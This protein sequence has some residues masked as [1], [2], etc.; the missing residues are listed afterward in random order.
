MVTSVQS[1]EKSDPMLLGVSV[2]L[3]ITVSAAKEVGSAWRAFGMNLL[4]AI[5]HQKDAVKPDS[6]GAGKSATSE[7]LDGSAS[8]SAGVSA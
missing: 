3:G 1:T 8:S 7:S 4:Q 5:K 6:A 2:P